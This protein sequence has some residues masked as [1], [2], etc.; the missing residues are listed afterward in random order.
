M[1]Y[2]APALWSRTVQ[3]TV[4]PALEDCQKRH[5]ATRR[6]PRGS[7]FQTA[8]TALA[9]LYQLCIHTGS[10]IFVQFT[11]KTAKP[12][13]HEK[14]S[15][16]SCV[17]KTCQAQRSHLRQHRRCAAAPCTLLAPP[18]ECGAHHPC[19]QE[20]YEE[21]QNCKEVSHWELICHMVGDCCGCIWKDVHEACKPTAQFAASC[22]AS[23]LIVSRQIKR[24]HLNCSTPSNQD[25]LNKNCSQQACITAV[26]HVQASQPY[27]L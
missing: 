22:C 8:R 1:T 4:Q 3:T 27:K 15:N 18:A 20:K 5:S 14:L 7:P 26:T 13:M 25:K 9:N 23:A 24:K 19:E 11:S 12:N 16:T 6:T 21:P 10:T 2:H 17:R